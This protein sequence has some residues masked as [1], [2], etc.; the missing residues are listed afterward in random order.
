[1]AG[2]TLVTARACVA[3]LS[4]QRGQWRQRRTKPRNRPHRWK[5]PCCAMKSLSSLVRY[6]GAAI[7]QVERRERRMQDIAV[8][9]DL[10]DRRAPGG[11]VVDLGEDPAWLYRLDEDAAPAAE[12]LQP[13]GVGLRVAVVAAGLDKEAAV[14]VQRRVELTAIP[15]SAGY[16]SGESGPAARRA[17]R[18]RSRR[19]ASTRSRRPVSFSAAPTAR[20]RSLRER[21]VADARRSS[22]EQLEVG[23]RHQPDELFEGGLRLPAQIGLGLGR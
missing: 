11:G 22:A 17:R 19:Q 6:V 15:C 2:T 21:P 9:D 13:R 12:A 16:V 18:A 14:A 20:A 7:Q 8:A 5:R 1:M 3:R 4:R 10:L 23:A